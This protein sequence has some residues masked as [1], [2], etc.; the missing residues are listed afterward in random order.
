[1]VKYV[2]S[3]KVPGLGVLGIED[4][5]DSS[6]RVAVGLR[7]QLWCN[8]SG[9]GGETSVKAARET[10]AHHAYRNLSL[11]KCNL[12]SRLEAVNGSMRLLLELCP[13]R[14]SEFQVD[15]KE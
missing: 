14:I 7:Y 10:L 12:L 5:K 9:I 8:G 15:P 3:F 11:E 13:T 4:R 1:M 2:E 6:Y